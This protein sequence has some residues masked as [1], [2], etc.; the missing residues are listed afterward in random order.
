VANSLPANFSTITYKIG[1][2]IN[3]L[4]I[5][6]GLSNYLLIR[7]L[8]LLIGVNRSYKVKKTSIS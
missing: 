6:W 8:T 5:S 4:I 2:L 1:R 3:W 7:H